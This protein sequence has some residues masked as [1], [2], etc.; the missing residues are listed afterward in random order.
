MRIDVVTIFPEMFGGVLGS[1]IL[2]IA[3]ERGALDVNLVDLRAFADDKRRTVDD[4]PFGGG[5]GMVFKVEPVVR[6]VRTVEREDPAPAERILLTP[7]GE[8]LTQTLIKELSGKGRLILIAGHYEG[9]DERIRLVLRPREVSIGDY[10]LTG[11]ELPAMVIIDAVAR[12]LP[13]VLGAEDANEFESFASG[14]LEYPQYTRPVEFEGHTVPEVLRSGDHGRVAAW[15]AS[16]A[17]RRTRERR[18]DLLMTND[19]GPPPRKGAGP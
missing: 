8:R 1:S 11:G 3:R 9:F 6:A 10:I 4:R 12:L 2:R 13:G 18:G 19:Q 14:L 15:R 16:E 17:L 5:P 7:Q